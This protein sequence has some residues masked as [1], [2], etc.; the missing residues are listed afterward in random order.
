MNLG[1][2][3]RL[4][5]AHVTK[6]N[7]ISMMLMRRAA[8][9]FLAADIWKNAFLI[10]RIFFNQ[11]VHFSN[12]RRVWVTVVKRETHTQNIATH[13]ALV[14]IGK[15]LRRVIIAALVEEERGDFFDG[16]AV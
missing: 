9:H 5:L 11:P 7:H 14:G 13:K 10:A 3:D 12:G 2:F 1:R 8:V 6:I 15:Q 4:V 16:F